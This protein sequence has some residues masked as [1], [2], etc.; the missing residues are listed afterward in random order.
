MPLTKQIIADVVREEIQDSISGLKTDMD[1]KFS[2]LEKKIVNLTTLVSNFASN[3]QNLQ[4]DHDILEGQV[5][6]R[7][8]RIEKLEIDAFG[9]IQVV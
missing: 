7:T 4:I 5:S 3:L 9:A 2:G 1:D 8:E 6:N